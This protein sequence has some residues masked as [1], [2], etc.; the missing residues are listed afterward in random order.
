[1][2]A[3]SVAVGAHEHDEQALDLAE[4]PSGRAVALME[5]ARRSPHVSEIRLR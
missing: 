3:G 1:M 5:R 4:R 2:A